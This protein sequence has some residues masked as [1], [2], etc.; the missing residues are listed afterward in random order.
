M[1]IVEINLDPTRQQLRMFGWLLLPF[2]ALVG[3]I[4][5]WQSANA[6]LASGIA[7]VIAATG[8]VGLVLRPFLLWV[9]RI[10]LMV[11]Y[12]IGWVMSHLMVA[13]VFYLLISPIGI[14]MRF[15]GRDELRRSFDDEC[16]S[17][18][19]PREEPEDNERYFRQF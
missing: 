16:E 13:I 12:P 7:G 9:Y 2:G 4:V 6:T 11:T 17:Y 10:W 18:W 14:V 1:A 19:T 15:A 5:F 3:L 8:L